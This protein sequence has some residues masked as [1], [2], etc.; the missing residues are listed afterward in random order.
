[1]KKSIS[2]LAVF[3]MLNL[4]LFPSGLAEE[5]FSTP[6]PITKIRINEGSNPNVRSKPS[7]DGEILG[8][9]KSEEIYELLAT[10]ENW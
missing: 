10:S 6:K 8:N 1:M 2:L 9:A 5:P 4:L 3:L 7:T